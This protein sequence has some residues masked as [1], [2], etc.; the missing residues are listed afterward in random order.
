M[1]PLLVASLA[2]HFDSWSFHLC[3]PKIFYQEI[4]VAIWN[5]VSNWPSKSCY[6]KKETWVRRG[7]IL[8][9]SFSLMD[10]WTIDLI[11]VKILGVYQGAKSRRT[12][13]GIGKEAEK[14]SQDFPINTLLRWS[15]DL[16]LPSNF[17]M[18]RIREVQTRLPRLIKFIK[19]DYW[20]TVALLMLVACS[21]NF[22]TCC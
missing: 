7:L 3:M 19:I 12:N 18:T 15:M 22:T 2:L 1:I 11:Q 13:F 5:S 8:K 9:S 21:F 4:F 6:I 16:L 14:I 20:F 17:E 10:G